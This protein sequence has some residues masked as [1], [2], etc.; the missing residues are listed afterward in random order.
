MVDR[1]PVATGSNTEVPANSMVNVFEKGSIWKALTPDEVVVD[2][3]ID[4][5]N[6]NTK[7]NFKEEF[8]RPKFN[9]AMEV[10]ELDR[11]K[12]QKIDRA[13]KKPVKKDL[14]LSSSR[15]KKKFIKEHN[16]NYSSLPHEWF[17]VFL[18]KN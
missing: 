12:R 6:E 18:P 10:Y 7:V 11:F 1:I 2:P 15:P 16:L 13:T 14:P 3:S 9:G 4:A 17:E 8:S 5:S